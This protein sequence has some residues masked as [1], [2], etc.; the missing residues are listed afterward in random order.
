MLLSY[1]LVTLPVDTALPQS[2]NGHDY[3]RKR[4]FFYAEKCLKTRF[5]F[6][7]HFPHYAMQCDYGDLQKLK[8][9]EPVLINKECANQNAN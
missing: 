7:Y 5:N 9:L 2:E 4:A 6:S 8:L 1:L 3:L